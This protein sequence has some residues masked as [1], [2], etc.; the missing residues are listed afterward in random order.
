MPVAVFSHVR[1]PTEQHKSRPVFANDSILNP[2]ILFAR[3]QD[4]NSCCMRSLAWPS[5]R[6]DALFEFEYAEYVFF[7]TY[8]CLDVIRSYLKD[9]RVN[10]DKLQIGELCN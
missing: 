4:R 6:K 1:I 3:D 8:F 5:F 9:S 7:T 10:Q 2:F